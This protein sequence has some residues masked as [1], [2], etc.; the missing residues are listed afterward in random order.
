M[1]KITKTLLFSFVIASNI[2]GTKIDNALNLLRR[3]FA[4][5][6]YGTK[7]KKTISITNTT[8]DPIQIL[9]NYGL[10]HIKT[11][12]NL[13]NESDPIKQENPISKSAHL[14]ILQ[15]LESTKLPATN[16]Q[17]ATLKRIMIQTKNF[18][19]A[20]SVKPKAEKGKKLPEQYIHE[21]VELGISNLPISKRNKQKF[22]IN[23]HETLD[24]KATN[25]YDMHFLVSKKKR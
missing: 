23:V 6:E 3:G 21:N 16:K 25:T 4:G 1:R 19:N 13:K 7:T 12:R 20:N 5:R 15:P 9:F 14:I 24:M 2:Q 22:D 8:A 11:I 18:N 10:Y 17:I